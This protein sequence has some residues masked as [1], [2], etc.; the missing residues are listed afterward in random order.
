MEKGRSSK[1]ENEKPEEKKM[2]P[3]KV[4]L[5][6]PIDGYEETA[7]WRAA[8]EGEMGM[9][10]NGNVQECRLGDCT[11]IILTPKVKKYDWSKTSE[12]VLVVDFPT[13]LLR[14]HRTYL[15]L[16]TEWIPYLGG[17][18]PFDEDAVIVEVM[19]RCGTTIIRSAKDINRDIMRDANA[20]RFVELVDGC[21][22]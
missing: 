1:K 21:I 10:V 8:R 7:E 3:T 16:S 14:A 19:Y 20:I 4:T 5:D 17:E 22:F 15:P 9:D 11:K 13:V 2:K 12:K 6:D 18:C